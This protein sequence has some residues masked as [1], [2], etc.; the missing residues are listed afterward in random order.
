MTQS[1]DK[2]ANLVRLLVKGQE[3]GG[4]KDVR[5]E[6]GIERQARSFD[7]TV[8]DRWPGALDDLPRRVRPGDECVVYIGDDRVAT[9][10]I[11]GT[12]IRYDGHSLTVGV[13]GR[14]KTADLVDCCPEQGS[15]GGGAGGGSAKKGWGALGLTAID[16]SKAG[17]TPAAKAVSANAKGGSGG[18]WRGQKLEQIAADMAAPYSIK[19]VAEV[20]TGAALAHQVQQGETV[21]ESID[22]M[23]RARH[24]LATDNGLGELVFV[25]AGS[26]GKAATALKVGENIKAG[27]TELDYKKVYSEYVCK[28]QRSITSQQT[29]EDEE[30]EDVET[31]VTSSVG[32]SAAATD[33]RIGRRR[34]L[35]LKQ[36][37]QA[38]EGT[39][40]DRVKFER[41][42]RAAKALETIYTVPGTWRQD[43]G[44]LW[45]PNQTVRVIDPIIGFDADMLIAEVHYLLD[46]QGMRTELKVGPL[47]GYV[48]AAQKKQKAKNV[49]IVKDR[50]AGKLGLKGI[51]DE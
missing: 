45:V 30:G 38:D 12:P 7:L 40:E 49:K 11:D 35:V 22:R 18:Q 41:A 4:W 26:G 23:L 50:Y 28:G 1:T 51:T 32:T 47:D 33:S 29:D 48:S 15:K 6:A 9:G 20:D 44:A 21:F 31:A 16:G 2:S 36:S 27:E 37:G 8:T 42:H 34:L 46:E 10:Y 17:S 14:S 5:I 25:V 3:Y 13:R 39:C 19:V 43:S 24:C